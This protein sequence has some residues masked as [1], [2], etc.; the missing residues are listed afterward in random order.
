MLFTET[1][2]L[3]VFAKQNCHSLVLLFVL[4]L[5]YFL[6]CDMLNPKQ[7]KIIHRLFYEW[8]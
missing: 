6:K 8:C 7:N 1:I 5:V 4:K 3:M 2:F